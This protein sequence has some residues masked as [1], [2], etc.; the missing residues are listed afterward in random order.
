MNDDGRTGTVFFKYQREAFASLTSGLRWRALFA[1]V[2]VHTPYLRGT[3]YPQLDNAD[4]SL[5]FGFAHR[6]RGGREWHLGLVE[7]LRP[8]GP[9]IDAVLRAGV[10]F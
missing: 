9:A 1:N 10:R 5:D 4:V 8:H 6:T 2:F 3:R 7:D